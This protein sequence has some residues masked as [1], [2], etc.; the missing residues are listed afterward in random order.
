MRIKQNAWEAL[1]SKHK[2]PSRAPS[3]NDIALSCSQWAGSPGFSFTQL[4]L[5]DIQYQY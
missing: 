2:P 4:D 3:A 1:S 5:V